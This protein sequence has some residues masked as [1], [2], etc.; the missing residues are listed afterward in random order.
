[1]KIQSRYLEQFVLDDL[2][3]KMVFIGGPRQVG[4]T[5]FSKQISPQ[6]SYLNWDEASHRE[7]ILKNQLP[8]S[9]LIIFDEIHKY[10]QWR[11]WLKGKYDTLKE[12]HQFLITGSARLDLYRFGGDSLQGRYFYYRLHPFSVHELGI[13]NK[14]DFL[15]LLKLSGFPEPFLGGK[16][17]DYKRWARDYRTRL[18][19]D[20]ITSL[21]RIDDIGSLELL[22]MRLPELVGSPL[23]INAL[24]EDLQKS[25]KTVSRWLDI[26][27]RTYGLFR[28][29]PFGSPKIKA[30]K[31]EQKHYHFDWAV[32]ADEA[33]RLENLV[34]SHLLK[35]CHFTEDT[36]GDTCDLRYFRDNDG[37]E[38]DF[39]VVKNKKPIFM[40]EVKSSAKQ[41]SPHLLYLKKKFPSTPAFQVHLDGNIDYIGDEGIKVCP[42]W[43]F[44]FE[45]N[46]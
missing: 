12:N 24:R 17:R 7:K 39:I 32:C 3:K 26:L 1:M 5:T 23:S 25:H 38:V 6:Y 15:D 16:E 8:D 31:K 27:E 14:K 45:L 33:Q 4:K 41:I 22:I 10:R 19:R 21:E 43:K 20:D 42:V 13:K 40:I 9:K 28:L 18:L 35:Y 36:E 11:N 29:Q 44:L 46:V 37:R 2:E 30:V 34:A